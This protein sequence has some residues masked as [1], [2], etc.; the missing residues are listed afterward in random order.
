MRTASFSNQQLAGQRLMVGFNGTRLNEDLKF[1]INR[2]KVGGVILFAG[3]LQSP[4]QIKDM[5]HAIQD[6]ARSCEQ[7]TFLI[8]VNQE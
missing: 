2:L 5:C 7:P 6:Y 3:N 1:L 4:D 8:A